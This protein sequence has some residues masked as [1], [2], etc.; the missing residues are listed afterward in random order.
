MKKPLTH[1]RWYLSAVFY[2]LVEARVACQVDEDFFAYLGDR[3]RD[4]I[5]ADCGCGP[6]IVVEKF[7]NRGAAKVYAIDVNPWMLIQTKRRVA[8]CTN[9]GRVQVVQRAFSSEFF[10]SLS[11]NG[12]KIS[13]NIIL[14][15]RSLYVRPMQAQRILP[16]AGQSLTPGG[17]L[18][19]IH[20]E[21]SLRR[22]AFGPGTQLKSH[23]I[24]YLFNRTISQ[25][26]D[27]MGI[28]QYTLYDQHE[29]LRLVRASLPD[30]RVES[31][32]T[33]QSAYNLVAAYRPTENK[34]ENVRRIET[35]I[36]ASPTT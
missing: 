22:Y 36:L 24:Y 26:G 17:M 7:L 13:F 34:E 2:R 35:A 4:A 3:V 10:Q 25:L 27:W 31:I 9:P 30:F 1:W 32:P 29:L 19:I 11:A 21:R 18:A 28:G 20:P 16:A 14:F 12:S 15:K 33:S 8:D 6:G 5:V 23:T